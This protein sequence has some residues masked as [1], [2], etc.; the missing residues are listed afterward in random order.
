MQ[1]TFRALKLNTFQN[2]F[3]NS[4]TVEVQVSIEY[5]PMIQECIDFSLLNL[6]ILCLKV[7]A[8]QTLQ[9]FFSPNNSQRM[10]WILKILLK[11]NITLNK[12]HLTHQETLSTS[13]FRLNRMQKVFPC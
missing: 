6:L 13:Q 2:K 1:Y 11:E 9:V 7:K 10:K 5:K 8:K 4:L 12:T 3:K